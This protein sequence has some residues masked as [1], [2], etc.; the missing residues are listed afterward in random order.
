[1]NAEDIGIMKI[2]IE[3]RNPT[4]REYQIL[5]GSTGWEDLDDST[6]EKGLENSLFAVCAIAG[7][8][9]VGIGR[10]IGD[11]AIYFYIQDVIVMP[12]FRKMGIGDRIMRELEEWLHK[13]TYRHSFI[14]LM[15]AEGVKDF[16]TRF[17]YL[18][19]GSSRPGMN[20]LRD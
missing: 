6:V 1:M 7:G 2:Q 12:A 16:Y 3:H 8:Q 18:E 17:G 20:K 11:G 15:A 4:L 9:T 13:N 14:G 19:R 10:I 5:R